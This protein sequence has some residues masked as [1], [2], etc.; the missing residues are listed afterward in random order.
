MTGYVRPDWV[1]RV[2]AMGPSIGD[3]AAVVPLDADELLAA[4]CR[5]TGLEDFGADTWREPYQRLVAALDTEARLHVLGRLM[6]RHD[7]LRHLSTRLRVVDAVA[8]QPEI[9][10]EQVVAPVVVTG[11]ARSGTSILQELLAQDPQ[12]RSPRAWEMAHPLPRAGGDPVAWAESEFD[13][14]GDV[15]PEFLAIHELDAALPEECLW[16]FA[17]QF[18][19]GFWSTCTDIPS[20]FAFRAGTDPAEAY[21]FHRTMLQV[22]QHGDPA[23]TE[24][25]R[26]WAL[27]SPVHLSR[28]AA[29]FAV[30][31]DARVIH[32]HR[33]PVKTVPSSASAVYGGR[34]L[35]SD[36]V[37]PLA[38][39]RS[40]GVGLQ[41]ILNGV[42]AQRSH[43]ELPES[44]F[45]DLHYLDLLR[46]P[47][48]TMRAAY[49]R[50]GLRFGDDLPARFRA[51]L[52]A[53]PQHKHGVHRYRPEDFGMDAA[54]LRTRFAPYTDRYGV[55]PEDA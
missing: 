39:G 48:T 28:L 52:D 53:R 31:P 35:R 20:W 23:S 51:Y 22:L 16:L 46:D 10:H 3:A 34:W 7:L 33:D 12:L 36:A 29:L 24:Q 47:I 17:P 19:L 30:Y 45:A 6:C 26:P 43:G 27:K 18:D 4:A 14:W 42:A 25:P 8:R 37:E 49:E 5:A 15:Q 21:R 1:R 40:V 11:P 38:T 9:A 32:T 2:V 13:L 50:L 54:D 44:Q 55:E 41:M